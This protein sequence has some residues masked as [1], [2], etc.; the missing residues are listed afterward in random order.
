[1]TNLKASITTVERHAA[2]EGTSPFRLWYYGLVC[3]LNPEATGMRRFETKG[4]QPA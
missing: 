4:P 2:W 3:E 1:M